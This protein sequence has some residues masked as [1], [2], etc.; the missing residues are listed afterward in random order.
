MECPRAVFR[1]VVTSRL[2]RLHDTHHQFLTSC[3]IADTMLLTTA[4]WGCSG[5]GRFLLRGVG[6]GVFGKLVGGAEYQG[7]RE[8]RYPRCGGI[9]KRLVEM[10]REGL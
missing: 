1:E 2:S 9:V 5:V 10:P 6:R 4:R 8:R 3:A 7:L